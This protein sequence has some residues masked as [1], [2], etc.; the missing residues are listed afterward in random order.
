MSQLEERADADSPVR[1][2]TRWTGEKVGWR[3][4]RVRSRKKGRERKRK[5]VFEVGV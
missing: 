2:K 5:K 4:D 1:Q 3:A